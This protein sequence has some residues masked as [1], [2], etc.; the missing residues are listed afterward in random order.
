MES[1]TTKPNRRTEEEWFQLIQE[2]RT[3]GLSDKEWCRQNNVTLS[4]FYYHIRRLTKKACSSLPLL[5]K[6]VFKTATII[7]IAAI[8]KIISTSIYPP[9]S[10]KQKIIFHQINQKP[11]K[12]C[13]DC[14]NSFD[15]APLTA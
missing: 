1:N 13:N 6:T 2:C 4:D 11:S 7:P 5:I 9:K 3:S 8:L 10:A 12:A 15:T 14:C